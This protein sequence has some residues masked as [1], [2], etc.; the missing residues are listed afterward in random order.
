MAGQE[1]G[2]KG[3]MRG[4]FSAS[5]ISKY[6]FVAQGAFGGDVSNFNQGASGPLLRSGQRERRNL[7]RKCCSESGQVL[8]SPSSRVSSAVTR[9]ASCFARYAPT[10]RAQNHS[11]PVVLSSS[12]PS[13]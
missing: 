9:V 1:A 6:Q 7:A 4:V 3:G 12:R 8:M 13:S 10:M 5:D 2:K 11:G